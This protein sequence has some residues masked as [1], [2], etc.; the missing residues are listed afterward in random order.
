MG[1]QP[2]LIENSTNT[3]IHTIYEVA[4]QWRHILK[5][6]DSFAK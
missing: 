1:A 5:S 4:Y 6:A 3:G 2:Y